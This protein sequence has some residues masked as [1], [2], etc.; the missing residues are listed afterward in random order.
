M[1]VRPVFV[2]KDCVYCERSA[3]YECK[4]GDAGEVFNKNIKIRNI[5][6]LPIEYVKYYRIILLLL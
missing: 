3:D 6:S 5:K 4:E 1:L 2:N